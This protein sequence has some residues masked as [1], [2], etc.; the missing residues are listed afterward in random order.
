M[1]PTD[2]SS[3]M[4]LIN[5][6]CFDDNGGSTDQKEEEDKEE[7]VAEKETELENTIVIEP[8]QRRKK[9]IVLGLGGLLVYRVYWY[10]ENRISQSQ[11]FRCPDG[12]AGNFLVFKRPFCDDFLRF[13]FE[14]FEV[15][16]WSSARR[17]NVMSVL[18]A[19]AGDYED[20][21]LFIWCQ[22]ECTDTG[23]KNI[24]NRGKP[25]YLKELKKIWEKEWPNGDQFSPSNTLFIDEEPCKALRNPPHTGIFPPPFKAD[26]VNDTFFAPKK[27]M[28]KILEGLAAT[29]EDVPSYVKQHKIG[30]PAIG[31]AHPHWNYYRKVVQPPTPLK[32]PGKSKQVKQS[33]RV[34]T[35]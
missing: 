16:L 22:E 30:Q 17:D 8:E 21:F 1:D 9:L 24:D 26:N 7:E 27:R 20:K 10:A 19:M 18:H 6:L 25:L 3:I 35:S 23:F 33:W 5:D 34:K 11:T 29:D 28:M 15:A 2:P 4:K 32:V 31:P 12:I 13:C 14:R